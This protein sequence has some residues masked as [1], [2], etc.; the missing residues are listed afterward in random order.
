MKKKM[1]RSLGGWGEE[2]KEEASSWFVTIGFGERQAA[3][4]QHS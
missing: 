2:G 4:V 1:G 3:E